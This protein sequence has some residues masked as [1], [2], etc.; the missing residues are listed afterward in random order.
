MRRYYLSR[1]S[2]IHVLPNIGRDFIHRHWLCG[3]AI[4]I[5]INNV[6]DINQLESVA[7]RSIDPFN[8]ILRSNWT[9]TVPVPSAKKY[10]NVIGLCLALHC[11]THWHLY[12]ENSRVSKLPQTFN[13]API[14]VHAQIISNEV[15]QFNWTV[16]TDY[17]TMT[18]DEKSCFRF[19]ISVAK[20]F[21]YRASGL[22]HSQ[23]SPSLTDSLKILP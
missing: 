23:P 18:L 19:C 16:I 8:S 21:R 4:V 6:V 7:L 20:F 17:T 13:C 12:A 5:F 3:Q 2:I 15:A 11:F 9:Y 10:F 1:T 14:K 22:Q